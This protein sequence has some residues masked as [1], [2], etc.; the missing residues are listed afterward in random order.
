ML[1]QGSRCGQLA[2]R[3]RRAAQLEGAQS[4][5]AVASTN[6]ANLAA[7][8]AP[9]QQICEHEHDFYPQHDRSPSQPGRLSNAFMRFRG[10]EKRFGN[11][12]ERYLNL[13]D[14]AADRMAAF[15][16]TQVVCWTQRRCSMSPSI[17]IF[18]VGVGARKAA[19]GDS[20]DELEKRG[21]VT[22]WLEVRAFN[23]AAIA[24]YESSGFNEATI[25]RNYYPTAQYNEDAIIMA[26][27]I[28]NKRGKG[29]MMKWD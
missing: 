21:V 15:T 17:R 20:I 11:R 23:A 2:V 9:W 4:R 28:C 10:S 6:L 1:P 7:R 24:L 13:A 14:Q 27:P 3:N 5:R 12:G 29:V 26:L 8:A 16:I 25:R 18:S 19:S 22:L